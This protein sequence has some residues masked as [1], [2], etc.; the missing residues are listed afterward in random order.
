MTEYIVTDTI[1][2]IATIPDQKLDD[3]IDKK[4]QILSIVD[5]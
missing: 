3:T 2:D 4:V 1:E 5:Y